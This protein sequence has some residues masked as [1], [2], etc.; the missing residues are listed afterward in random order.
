[1]NITVTDQEQC[2]KQLRLEIPGDTVRAE[3]DK[4]AADLARKVDVPGFRRGHVPK[5]VVKT[6]FRKELRDEMLSQI[7]PHSLGDA[8][9]EKELKVIG[10]PSVEDLKFKDDESIDVTFNLEV[11]PEFTLSKYQELPLTKNI[12]KVSDEDV[13]KSIEHLRERQ[14]QLVPVEDRGAETGDLVTLNLAGQIPVAEDQ[15]GEPEEIKQQDLD[16]ELGAAGVLKEFTEGLAGVKPGDLRTF[17][18]EYP[19]DY[20]P[21]K[22]AGRAVNYTAEVTAVRAKELPEIDDDFA[23]TV[24]EDFKTI[25]ELRADIRSK[26]EHEAE[27]KSDSEFRSS[28]MEKLIDRNRFDVPEYV[29]EKQIDSRMN[30]LFRQMSGRGMDPR[31][32]QIDWEGIREGQRER[33]EREVRGSFIL[34]H[35]AEKEKI[36]VS[37]EELSG[38]I[39]QYAESMGQSE[40]VLRA[41]LTKEGSLDSITEQVRHRKALDFVIASAEIRTEEKEGLSANEATPERQQAEA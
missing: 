29:V 28:T 21:E 13:D 16:V 24:S 6:R 5:S 15:P 2:R 26:L 1:M 34:D 40:E 3:T 8:I 22:F 37:D 25:D 36:E 23:R 4:I 32:L 18:V 7:L 33:A 39:R 10:E 30:S 27:H 38:E 9:R 41:R 17:T 19:A 31:Q 11:A 35:I 20:K 12:Y 14:T